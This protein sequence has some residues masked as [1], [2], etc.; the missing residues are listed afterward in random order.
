VHLAPFHP[1]ADD[2]QAA[3]AALL[4]HLDGVYGFALTLTG[5]AEVAAELTEDVFVNA[6]D[7]LWSTLGGH[8]LRDRLL[9]RCVS[10]FIALLASG[11]VRAS[12]TLR[13]TGP[14]PTR[15]GALLLELPWDERAAV[16][17]VDQLRL[18][19]QS[20]AAVLDIDVAEFRVLL[21]SGRATL[22]A[23]FRAGAR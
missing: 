11:S 1:S 21:H 3:P 16:A 12:R 10:A 6:R 18:T 8:S 19:Y 9:A 13:R 23:A 20:A 2:D 14:R 5:D 17:L 4:S 15:L 7:D 22:F